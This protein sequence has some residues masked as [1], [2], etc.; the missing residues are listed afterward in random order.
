MKIKGDDDDLSTTVSWTKHAFD[1]FVVEGCLTE[2]EIKV[3]ETRVKGMTI[4]EQADYLNCSK[5]TVD[6]TV[7]KLKK[8]YD[9]VREHHPELPERNVNSITE[10]YLD[11]H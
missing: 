11:T 1:V 9:Q 6:R 4:T 7:K 10:A 2:F 3:L 5:S 8:R